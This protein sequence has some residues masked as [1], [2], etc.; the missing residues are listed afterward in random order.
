MNFHIAVYQQS[1]ITF[2]PHKTLGVYK[3]SA[4]FG[5]LKTSLSEKLAGG[6]TIPT[7]GV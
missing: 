5:F 4:M 1:D 3:A 7:A 6:W 2:P